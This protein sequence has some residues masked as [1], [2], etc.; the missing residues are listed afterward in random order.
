VQ[1]EQ[2]AGILSSRESVK[3]ISFPIQNISLIENL[4]MVCNKNIDCSLQMW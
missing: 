4:I 1:D 3:K 2:L